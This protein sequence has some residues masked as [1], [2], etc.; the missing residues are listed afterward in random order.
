MNR[1][2]SDTSWWGVLT[3]IQDYLDTFPH[4]LIAHI[5]NNSVDPCSFELLKPTD[6]E[7]SLEMSRGDYQTR[8]N[9]GDSIGPSMYVTT[10]DD[11]EKHN[12]GLGTMGFYVDVK[13]QSRPV[14]TAYGVTN[15]HVVRPCFDGFSLAK[16]NE[17][18][19]VKLEA[20]APISGSDCHD[21]DYNGV[22]PNRPF[23]RQN[24]EAPPRQTHNITISQLRIALSR[25]RTPPPH[26]RP[27]ERAEYHQER[28][29]LELELNQKLAFF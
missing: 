25:F 22:V 12:P 16:V 8:V 3:R 13:T 18:G 27:Q 26:A 9:L 14:W 2:I 21:A 17:N 7:S 24:M 1:E 10:E 15:Y 19:R 29:R 6:P 5:E 4:G 11:D 20:D 28:D 23:Q